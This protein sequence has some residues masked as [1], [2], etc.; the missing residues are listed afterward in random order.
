MSVPP[1][2]RNIMILAGVR[3]GMKIREITRTT[4]DKV[5]AFGRYFSFIVFF[6]WF[7]FFTSA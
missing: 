4:L 5:I 6:L 1:A 7:M 2:R 3:G